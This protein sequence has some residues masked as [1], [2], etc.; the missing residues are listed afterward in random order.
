MTERRRFRLFLGTHPLQALAETWLLGLILLFLLS[1]VIGQLPPAVFNNGILAVCGACGMWMVVRTRVPERSLWIQALWELG[2]GVALSALMALGLR[3]SVNLL[4]WS[5]VWHQTTLGDLVTIL[6]LLTG[7]GYL[8]ARGGVR[9]LRYWDRLRRRRMLV[10]FIHAH[11][12]VA[13]VVMAIFAITM[14]LGVMITERNATGQPE[15][16]GLMAR[17]VDRLFRT[18][19]PIL[20]ISVVMMGIVTLALLPLSAILSYFLAR[21][22]T[23]RLQELAE[24]A[25]AMRAGDYDARVGVTGEDE[26]AQLHADFNVMAEE[27]QQ[28]M[29]ELKGERD[30]VSRLLASRRDLLA[31]V[32]HELRTPVATVRATLESMLNSPEEAP[33]PAL[34]HDLEV[35]E[36]E[37]VRLQRLI[38][39]LFALS[40]AEVAQLSLECCPVDV[41]ALV[42]RMVEA[43]AP[44]AWS[45]GRIEVVSELPEAL[46]PAL[47]DASRLEQ[48]LA[49]LLRNAIRY[50]PPGGI[51]AVVA[52]AGEGD[53]IRIEVRD[54][55]AG[56]PPE[57]LPHIWE[58]FYRG[59]QAQ[60]EEYRGAGLGLALVRELTEAMG[61]TVAVESEV[62][63]GSC[64]TLWFPRA[65]A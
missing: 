21:R 18:A 8:V 60:S 4:G 3:L 43:V 28:T 42:R 40:Q 30:T 2:V 6:F 34:R 48:V 51:V 62:G 64:F 56:I 52:A 11:L 44:L 16:I 39:D 63:Q 32:S 5:A 9:L 22:T 45:A 1:Q 29:D 23:R 26:V 57:E 38:D 24:T 54:T 15:G 58:R 55:G 13:L 65:F 49:N 46:P 27:L 36:G 19:F 14:S 31:N 20:G 50:T 25:G 53:T 7:P 10:S 41:L 33:K 12:V 61:G 47:V 17:F 59:E 37:I 35:V